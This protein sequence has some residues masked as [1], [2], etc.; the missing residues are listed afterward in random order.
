M[1]KKIY[2]VEKISPRKCITA[3]EQYNENVILLVG[4]CSMLIEHLPPNLQSFLKEPLDKVK[5]FYGD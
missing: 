5:E 1:A 4:A 3:L 2:E